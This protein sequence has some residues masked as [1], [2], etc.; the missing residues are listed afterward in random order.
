M[1][2]F[3]NEIMLKSGL[4]HKYFIWRAL[5]HILQLNY[6]VVVPG[7]AVSCVEGVVLRIW[8]CYFTGNTV[9]FSL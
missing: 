6:S 1:Y 2:V 5:K 7:G 9:G 3:F 8:S 4:Y